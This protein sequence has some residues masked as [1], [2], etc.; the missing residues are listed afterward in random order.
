M[1]S[2][3]FFALVIAGVL[4][5]G[6]TVYAQT[7]ELYTI[8][9][10]IDLLVKKGI[11]SPENQAKANQLVALLARKEGGIPTAIN[12]DKVSVAVSQLIEY[13][14]GEYREGADVQGLLLVVTNNTDGKVDLEAV[15]KC[16]VTYRIYSDKNKLLYDYSEVNPNCKGPEKVTYAL[17]AH[18]SRM[19]EV[20]HKISEYPLSPGTYRFELQ[21][22]GYG[23]GTRII[24]VI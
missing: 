23:K 13:G 5:W 4:M 9:G 16:Q 10:F 18:K 11:I 8:P 22:P 7:T 19:F 17:E 12:A 15:R 6:V 21:Y 20:R 2:K 24:N 3:S 1:R 14:T